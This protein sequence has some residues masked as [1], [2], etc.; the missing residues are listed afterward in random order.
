MVGIHMNSRTT[1]FSKLVVAGLSAMLASCGGDGT[2]TNTGTQNAALQQN[3]SGALVI[4]A[5]PISSG[6]HS[7]LGHADRS[8]LE[9]SLKNATAKEIRSISRSDLGFIPSKSGRRSGNLVGAPQ[10]DIAPQT[11]SSSTVAAPVA[12]CQEIS[13]GYVYN[14]TTP[15]S[16]SFKCY[17]FVIADKTKIDSQIALPADVTAVAGLYFVDPA[18]GQLTTELDSEQTP[19]PLLMQTVG[20]NMRIVLALQPTNGTGGQVFQ[21]GTWSRQG[22]DAYE[23]NDK[24]SRAVTIPLSKNIKANIDAPS[25]DEDYYFYPFKPG[26]TS[27]GI[28]IRFTSNQAVGVRV[29][30]QT[31]PGAFSWGAETLIPADYSGKS[32]TFSGVPANT[33]GSTTPYGV[34][35]RVRGNNASAPSA[36]PY[37]LRVGPS[38]GYIANINQWNNEN[39]SRW[40]PTSITGI[41]VANYLGMSIN[42]MDS[43]GDPVEGEVVRFVYNSNT[44]DPSIQK[45]VLVTTDLFGNASYVANFPACTGTVFSETGY[46]AFAHPTQHWNGTM[47]PGAWVAQLLYAKPVAPNEGGTTFKPP[48]NFFHICSETTAGY[49]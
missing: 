14:D 45:D 37:S 1:T 41:Q 42:V 29:A 13:V 3:N 12:G 26:Q 49:Y 6:G 9:E 18:S 47:Q 33:V 20:Q 28:T 10:L 5:S 27:E 25:V 39:I 43:F 44:Q 30:Q 34:M 21:F 8:L 15:A 23:P 40:Y 35:I 48:L 32:F 19:N 31:G 2:V 11:G 4:N 7:S 38:T 17:Q 16:G 24:P 46:G 22:F 36:E